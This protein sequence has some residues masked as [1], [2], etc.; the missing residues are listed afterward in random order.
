MVI[1]F[2]GKPVQVTECMSENV[3]IWPLGLNG[4]HSEW[5]YLFYISLPM[6]VVV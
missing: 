6:Q 5:K 4:R 1:S 3:N 2:L